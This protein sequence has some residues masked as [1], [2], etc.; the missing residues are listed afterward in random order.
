MVRKD[1]VVDTTKSQGTMA[2]GR[3]CDRMNIGVRSMS[4][5]ASVTAT[6]LDQHGHLLSTSTKQYGANVF[7][8]VDAKTSVG[9]TPAPA[10]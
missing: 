9:V 1:A 6:L 8:Q 4:S 2:L 7:E 3:G 5:G 10:M